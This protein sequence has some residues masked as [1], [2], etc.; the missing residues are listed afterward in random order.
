MSVE[1]ASLSPQLTI[2]TPQLLRSEVRRKQKRTH[3]WHTSCL[4]PSQTNVPDT[5]FTPN[6]SKQAFLAVREVGQHAYASPLIIR[7]SQGAACNMLCHFY[8]GQCAAS[9]ERWR[10]WRW[11][12]WY[13]HIFICTYMGYMTLPGSWELLFGLSRGTHVC[14]MR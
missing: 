12:N 6:R 7:I 1:T 13:T 11:R 14:R 3:S 8:V 10:D 4:G 9:D 2:I 5:F